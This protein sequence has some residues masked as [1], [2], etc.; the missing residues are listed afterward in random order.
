MPD[1]DEAPNAPDDAALTPAEPAEPTAA[2]P[3]TAST[4]EPESLAS[5]HPVD[6]PEGAEILPSPLAA[7]AR[8][9]VPKSAIIGVVVALV[10]AAGA[11]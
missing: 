3:E 4:T 9:G 10:V 2:A 11:P 5:A 1:H 7:P 6:A 8:P